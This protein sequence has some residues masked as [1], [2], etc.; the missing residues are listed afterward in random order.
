MMIGFGLPGLVREIS[1][2]GGFISGG[3]TAGIRRR[4]AGPRIAGVGLRGP[5]PWIDFSMVFEA[6]RRRDV[7]AVF[8]CRLAGRGWRAGESDDDGELMIGSWR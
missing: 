4:E 5:F 1:G 2:G 6:R 3:W 7:S 8:T